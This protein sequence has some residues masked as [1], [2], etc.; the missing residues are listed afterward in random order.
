MP[1]E[2]IDISSDDIQ[3]LNIDEQMTSAKDELPEISENIA[4]PLEGKE[5]S[6]EVEDISANEI[7]NLDLGVAE[8]IEPLEEPSIDQLE[9]LDENIEPLDKTV[10][11]INEEI[12]EE[13]LKL[14]DTDI[15]D[16]I[17]D[18]TLKNENQ[19]AELPQE[20]PSNLEELNLDS[21]DDLI[22]PENV[23]SETTPV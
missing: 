9:L 16:N 12:E 23:N 1:D 19:T 11:P 14:L 13:G 21:I 15:P 17:E 5:D 10:E 3:P 20:E 8:N 6:S 4:E 7:E 18:S 2:N 22:N